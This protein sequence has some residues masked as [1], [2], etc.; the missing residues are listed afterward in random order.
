MVYFVYY[1][2]YFELSCQYTSASDCLER[3]VSEVTY[4]V[5]SGTQNATH[6]LVRQLL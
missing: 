3:Q 2:V 6:S 5:S 1:L 4:C